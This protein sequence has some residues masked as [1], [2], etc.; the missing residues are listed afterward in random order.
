M[1]DRPSALSMSRRRAVTIP[2]VGVVLLVVFGLLSMYGFALH[3]TSAPTPLACSSSLIGTDAALMTPD[4]SDH[5]S[6]ATEPSLVLTAE[7]SA[8]PS[9]ISDQIAATSASTPMPQHAHNSAAMLCLFVLALFS[10]LLA[11]TRRAWVAPRLAT[12]RLIPLL[13]LLRQA[14]PRTPSLVSLCVSRT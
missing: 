8:A 9:P 5:S 6:G 1:N 13:V 14:P 4:H 10:L 3:G 11:P 12:A 7:N 2:L